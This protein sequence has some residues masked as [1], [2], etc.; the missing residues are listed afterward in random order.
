MLA[1]TW[2]WTLADR[3]APHRQAAV[4]LIAWLAEPEFSARWSRQLGLL[5]TAPAQLD[6]WPRDA[7]AALASRL[8]SVARPSPALETWTLFGPPLRA[9]LEQVLLEGVSAKAAARAAADSL[10]NP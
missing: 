8:L 6:L 2:A 10:A 9:A 4:D 7:S 5:P 1:R 3:P